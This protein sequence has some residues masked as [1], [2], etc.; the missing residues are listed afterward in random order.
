MTVDSEGVVRLLNR[1]LMSWTQVAHTRAH[2]SCSVHS[3]ILV[4]CL[5]GLFPGTTL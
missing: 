5:D 2:V 1:S 3:K 4:T